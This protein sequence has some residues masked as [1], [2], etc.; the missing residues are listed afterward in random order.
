MLKSF[1]RGWGHGMVLGG[2]ALVILKL[3]RIGLTLAN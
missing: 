3:I 1:M 2:T